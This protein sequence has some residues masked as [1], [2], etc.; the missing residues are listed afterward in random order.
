MNKSR[1]EAFSDGVIAILIT[2]M[3]LEL[4]LPKDA[5]WQSL[6]ELWPV[7]VSYLISFISLGIYWVNHHH[8][9]HTVK[10][11]SGGIM[12]ANLHL[13]FWL[14]LVPF[15]TGWMGESHFARNTVI[16]YTTLATIAGFAY[17][18]LISMIRTCNKQDERLKI[19]LDKQS[20]KGMWSNI[21]NAASALL[22]FIHPAISLGVLLIV[23]IIW[24]I[25]DKNIEKV[26]REN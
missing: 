8:L 7:V 16:A 25:P 5:N 22:A 24:F 14:S 26:L 17:Y 13:L 12:W 21:L 1:L 23:Y 3:V 6:K 11:I 19:V 15:A 4:K 10:T 18:I 9:I 20:K 2:I